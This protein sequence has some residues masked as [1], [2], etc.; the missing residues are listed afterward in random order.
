[1]AKDTHEHGR[2]FG[3]KQSIFGADTKGHDVKAF[4]DTTAKY[5]F[6]DAS[7]NTFYVSGTLDLDGAVTVGVDDTGYDVTFFGATSGKKFFWDES[8][9]TAYL[10]CTVDIDGTVTVGVDDTGYDVK[11]F[12]ATAGKYWLWDESADTMI[13]SGVAQLGTT[14]TAALALGGGTSGSPLTT[15]TADKNF[16]GFWTQSTA[17]SGD[18]RG[19][20]FRHYLGGT[21]ASTGYGDGI[22]AFTTVTGTGYS[23]ASGAHA[24]MQINA[25]ATVT[26]SGSGL[27]A[28]LAAAADTRTLV[29]AL[30][31]IHACSDVAT[32]NTVPTVHGFMRFTDDGA[33]RFTNLMVIPNV[34]NGTIFAAHTTQTLTHSIKI[35][36]E[37]G[38][39]YYVMCTNAATNRS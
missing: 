39:A 19:V 33:V 27:R 18:S 29:G 10:T 38:T 2:H 28:T 25:S 32:G 3:L 26:G 37:D 22:R 17:T 35:I 11:F 21:I 23:Y 31:S 15:A 5:A 16:V 7:A 14:A 30:S 24:T 9:D 8:A 6:W 1:M 34:S 13:I 20:Y 36:S 4:G 12:G